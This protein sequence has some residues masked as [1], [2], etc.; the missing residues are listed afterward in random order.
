MDF[1]SH[2]KDNIPGVLENR[3]S[4]TITDM[5]NISKKLSNEHDRDVYLGL[6]DL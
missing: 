6:M 2:G 5:Y 1:V 3:V 4:M